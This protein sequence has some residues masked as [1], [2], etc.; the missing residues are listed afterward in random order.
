M[1]REF[2]SLEALNRRIDVMCD[3]YELLRARVVS[4]GGGVSGDG[5]GMQTDID[6]AKRRQDARLAKLSD[7][8]IQIDHMVDDYTDR[9]LKL[10]EW[11]TANEVGFTPLE[12]AVIIARYLEFKRFDDIALNLRVSRSTVYNVFASARTK[13]LPIRRGNTSFSETA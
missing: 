3:E 2:E 13:I 4:A 9:R 8:S 11:I 10:L 5:T 12:S 7:L 6:S 1:I